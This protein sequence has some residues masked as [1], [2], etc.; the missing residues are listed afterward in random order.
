MNFCCPVNSGW[1]AEQ[2]STPISFIVEPVVNT[3]PQAQWTRASGYQ[4][5]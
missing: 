4:V 3:L 2:I 1:H 5:G